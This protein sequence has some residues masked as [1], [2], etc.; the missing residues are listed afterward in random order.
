MPRLGG[1]TV[2]GCA[3]RQRGFTLVELLVVMLIIGLLTGVATVAVFSSSDNEK[4]KRAA[5]TLQTTVELMAE[6]AQ[7]QGADYGL[8]LLQ[9]EDDNWL[10]RWYRLLDESER[11]ENSEEAD[12]WLPLNTQVDPIFAA[13]RLP[14]HIDLELQLETGERVRFRS[15]REEEL[16]QILFFSNG[17]ITPFQ[18]QLA[19]ANGDSHYQLQA[20]ML[21]RVIVEDKLDEP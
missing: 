9:D 7:L 5:R 3:R 13:T 4:I 6:E 1:S 2:A 16:P 12:W 15:G 8:L 11:E 20:D 18:L 10:Y 14:R 21:G 19:S 17:E